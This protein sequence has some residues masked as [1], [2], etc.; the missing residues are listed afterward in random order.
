MS[1]INIYSLFLAKILIPSNGFLVSFPAF[2]MLLS[3]PDDEL[4]AKFFSA[5][6]ATA[7]F[8]TIVPV[9]F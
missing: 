4:F 7:R 8:L 3:W 9:A 1:Y 2:F 5:N 6:K